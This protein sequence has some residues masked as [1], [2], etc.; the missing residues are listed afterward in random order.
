MRFGRWKVNTKQRNPWHVC[1][2]HRCRELVPCDKAF[3]PK[4]WTKLPAKIREAVSALW[5]TEFRRDVMQEAAR[6][7]EVEASKL[8]P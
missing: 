8:E 5:Y 3:C 6:V 1:P 4:C 2:G 7:S